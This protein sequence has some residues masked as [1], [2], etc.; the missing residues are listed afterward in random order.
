[1][2]VGANAGGPSESDRTND[3]RDAWAT[4]K[5]RVAFWREAAALAQTVGDGHVGSMASQSVPSYPPR[6]PRISKKGARPE[7]THG[8]SK[9]SPSA[10]PYFHCR[11]KSPS[12]KI[13]YSRTAQVRDKAFSKSGLKLILVLLD[14]IRSDVQA[15]HVAEDSH[16]QGISTEKRAD[17]G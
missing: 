15:G 13:K 17:L 8:R 16:M 4:Q 2:S 1:M 14:S 5:V 3:Q 9:S 7:Y 6:G 11:Q 12:P 10:R